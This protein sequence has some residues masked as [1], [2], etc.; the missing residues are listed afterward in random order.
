[1]ETVTFRRSRGEEFCGLFVLL[2]LGV[3]FVVAGPVALVDMALRGDPIIV[4]LMM[5][6]FGMLPLVGL[7][8]LWIGMTVGA[9]RKLTFVGRDVRVHR[10]VTG[11]RT[12]DLSGAVGVATWTNCPE[13]AAPGF[14]AFLSWR[15]SPLFTVSIQDLPTDLPT[16]AAA[17]LCLPVQF[18]GTVTCPECAFGDA[19]SSVAGAN[20]HSRRCTG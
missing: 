15:G 18:L 7:G 19:G 10:W 12:V 11:T 1:M 16:T 4:V 5:A 6:V 8:A 14:M 13:Q 2:P 9:V 20:R 17:Y 3:V